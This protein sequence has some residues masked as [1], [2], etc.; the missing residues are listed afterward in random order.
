M[1]IPRIMVMELLRDAHFGTSKQLRIRLSVF[2]GDGGG[3]TLHIKDVRMVMDLAPSEEL[4]NHSWA[5]S[6]GGCVAD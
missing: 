6:D 5:L 1:V 2:V 3:H 4:K